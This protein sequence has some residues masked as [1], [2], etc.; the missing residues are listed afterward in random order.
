MAEN[1]NWQEAQSLEKGL[2]QADLTV[3]KAKYFPKEMSQ[4]LEVLKNKAKKT[5]E[6]W[7]EVARIQVRL[8]HKTGALEGLLEAKKLDPIRSDIDKMYFEL[9]F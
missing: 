9:A 3:I 7:L 6:D 4:Q 1:G 8:G 2:N 5:V